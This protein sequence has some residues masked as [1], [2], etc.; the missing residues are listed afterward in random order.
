M[1]A[2]L[3]IALFL[4]SLML[5]PTNNIIQA[6]IALSCLGLSVRLMNKNQKEV[7]RTIENFENKVLNI[8]KIK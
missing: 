8:L 3:I 4:I 1:K 6:L 5:M 7:T 2:K